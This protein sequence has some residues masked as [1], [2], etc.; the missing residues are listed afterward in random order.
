[1]SL[2]DLIIK[3]EV[4]LISGMMGGEI[5]KFSFFGIVGVVENFADEGIFNLF[6]MILCIWAYWLQYI[7]FYL[8][9]S[10]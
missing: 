6:F 9:I 2:P 4:L 5:R 7:Y 1:M 3:T 10:K 8:S